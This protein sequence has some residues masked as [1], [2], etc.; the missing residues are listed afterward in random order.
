MEADGCAWYNAGDSATFSVSTPA[1]GTTGTQYLLTSWAGSGNGAYSGSNSS[2]I[3]TMDNPIT[4]TANWQTQYLVTF[5]QTGINSD[6]GTNTALLY[7]DQPT[8]GMLCPQMF[9][10]TANHVQLVV[11]CHWKLR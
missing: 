4:E 8:H 3:V 9:G 1:T 6:A 10:L 2:S 7:A 11:S 5:T